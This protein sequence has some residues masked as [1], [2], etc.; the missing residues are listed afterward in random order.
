MKKEEENSWKLK[1]EELLNK[2]YEKQFQDLKRNT[3]QMEESK[4]FII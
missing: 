3:N 2:N 1:Y 4:F